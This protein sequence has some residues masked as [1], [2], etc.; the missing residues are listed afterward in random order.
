MNLKTW[1]LRFMKPIKS[2]KDYET[3]LAFAEKHF[4]AK[5][6][7]PEANIAEIIT[8]LLEKYEEENFPIEAPDP[9]DAIKFRMEQLGM[10]ITDLVNI[11]GSKSHVSEVLSH[12]RSL[13]IGMIRKLHHELQIPAEVLIQ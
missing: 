5:K 10:T 6:G 1:F 11:M 2:K 8:I 12:K 7:T 3:A 13:S 9:I 4:F